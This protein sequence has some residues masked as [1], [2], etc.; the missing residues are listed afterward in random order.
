M[1][2]PMMFKFTGDVCVYTDKLSGWGGGG[3]GSRKAAGKPRARFRGLGVLVR[4]W[5]LWAKQRACLTSPG[6]SLGSRTP[7]T[8]PALSK[9]QEGFG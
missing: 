5:Q 9:A 1:C 3:G 7:G 4:A 8:F 6:L 2:E